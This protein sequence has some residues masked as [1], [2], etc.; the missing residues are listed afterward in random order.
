MGQLPGLLHDDRRRHLPPR[1]GDH[2]NGDDGGGWGSGL[3]RVTSRGRGVWFRV[4]IFT[5]VMLPMVVVAVLWSFIY[6]PDFGLINGA[7]EAAGLE[8]TSASGSGTPRRPCS[9]SASSRAGCTR[10]ST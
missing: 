8:I 6:N 9:R 4:A 5:P 2:G 7:L 10:A 3:E 1:Q